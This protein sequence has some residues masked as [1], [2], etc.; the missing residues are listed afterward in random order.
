MVDKYVIDN[1]TNIETLNNKTD[2]IQQYMKDM[3]DETQEY[4]N[5]NKR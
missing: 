1:N 3:T 4:I 2:T 5:A